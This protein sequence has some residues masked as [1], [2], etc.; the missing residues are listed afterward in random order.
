MAAA[1]EQHFDENGI[2]WPLAIA[3]FQVHLVPVSADQLPVADDLYQQL[4]EA[5][6]ETLVDD[7]NERPGV[8]FKDADLIGIPV[9]ITI[10]PKGLAQGEVEVKYRQTGAEER[11]PLAEVV[12]KVKEYL[13]AVG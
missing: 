10:G 4:N 5:G 6:V 7:R 2:K 3:P 1:I 13:V 12:T 9:R 11:W 8:K